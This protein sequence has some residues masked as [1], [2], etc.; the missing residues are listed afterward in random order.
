M[1]TVE[2]KRFQAFS[3]DIRA[4]RVD[5]VWGRPMREE[6]ARAALRA[7]AAARLARAVVSEDRWYWG[8]PVPEGREAE[9]AR[10]V[11]R[12]NG[13][14]VLTWSTEYACGPVAG[15]TARMHE[16]A[17]RLGRG[18]TVIAGSPGMLVAV[19]G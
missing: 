15:E 13:G 6:A 17:R 19:R 8:R 3:R 14:R 5:P 1:S 11:W 16:V 9:I 7:R 2:F 10:T 18:W 12:S 4:G